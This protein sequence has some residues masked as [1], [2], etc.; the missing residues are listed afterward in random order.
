MM[1]TKNY[2]GLSSSFHDPAI[3]IVDGR[4][5]VVFAES[6]E[7]YYQIKQGLFCPPDD[8]N[9]IAELIKTHCDPDAELVVT[10]TWAKRFYLRERLYVFFTET[11]R[12]LQSWAKRLGISS[13]KSEVDFSFSKMILRLPWLYWRTHIN[14]SERAGWSLK[15]Q[16]FL[17]NRSI[18][19]HVVERK[20]FNHHLTHAAT[21]AFTSP[22]EEA[23]V[24]IVDGYGEG[25]ST[26]I[27]SYKEGRVRP[28][29]GMPKSSGSLG[30]FYQVVCELCGFDSLKGE[31]WK[32]MGLAPY[33]SFSQAA[34]D[35]LKPLV[36]VEG[37][38]IKSCYSTKGF[39]SLY[40]RPGTPS[41][42][43]KDVAFTGQLVF[44]KTLFELLWNVHALGISDNLAYG[45][46]CALNSSANG[47]ILEM[48][49]F[50]RLH[51]FSAPADD[52]NAVGAALLAYQADNPSAR[53]SVQVHSPYLGSRL[54]FKSL[55][56]SV[57]LGRMPLVHHGDSI[58]EVAAE[59]LAEGNIIGWFQGQAEFGPRALGNRSI[60][61]D[62]RSPS[63]KER[64]NDLVKFREEFRPFAPSILDEYGESYFERY[65]R[66]PYMERT[67]RF[68]PE[69]R[70]RVPGVVH[71][72]G[73]GRLQSV[74]KSL[75]PRYHA[76]IQEFH[77][78]TGVPLILNTS[79]NVMGKPI[80][81]SLQDALAVFYTT[82]LDALVIDDY[83]IVKAAQVLP[84]GGHLDLVS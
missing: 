62:P 57:E 42:S 36:R 56:H 10:K 70:G 14:S 38:R 17:I 37:L 79:F 7:R 75:N 76:L 84:T 20:G 61:A 65:Q 58:A 50:K 63:I 8:F 16:P 46:G 83:L 77:R 44:E 81:H 9:R 40:R 30:F 2:V 52:G 34:Y 24:V 48:T 28:I 5:K 78:L 33:G 26:G 66:S 18:R 80:V 3:A 68:R 59:L 15:M 55:S 45:G 67:L 13:N 51:V 27:Y 72:D 35:I 6:Q 21:A 39:G 31:E 60:L 19:H 4:G 22:F 41:I 71:V 12:I 43:A 11:L 47:K 82:G 64:I 1:K 49:P 23:V 53:P 54:S 32:V 29:P 74:D 69:V 25:T 73:T